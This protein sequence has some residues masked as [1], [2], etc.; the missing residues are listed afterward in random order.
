MDKQTEK[1]TSKVNKSAQAY[2]GIR[3]KI[4]SEEFSP[5]QMLSE[6]ELCDLLGMSRTPIREALSR[7]AANGY[8]NIIPDQGAFVTKFHLEDLLEW[9]DVREGLESVAARWFALRHN[10]QSLAILEKCCQEHDQAYPAG[11]YADAVEKD[12]EFHMALAQGSCNP[13]LVTMLSSCI[14]HCKRRKSIASTMAEDTHGLLA[15]QHRVIVDAIRQGDADG[16]EQAVKKH[17]NTIRDVQREYFINYYYRRYE[18]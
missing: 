15:Q 18:V 14:A 1:G 17:I 10:D 3:D 2:D 8:V 9:Y 11:N 13:H 16:A 7:L 4:L 6:R 5:G 12:D